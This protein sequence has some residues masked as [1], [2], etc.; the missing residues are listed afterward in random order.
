M[1]KILP[2]TTWTSLANGRAGRPLDPRRVKGIALHYPA[3]GNVK[4]AGLTQNEIAVKL[5]SYRTHHV[6]KG[7]ADIGYNFAVDQ[8]GRVWNLTGWNIGAHAGTQGNPTYVG[9][10]LVLGNTEQPSTSMI[11]ALRAFRTENLLAKYPKATDVKG[12]QQIPGNSTACPGKPVLDLI[13]SKQ[14]LDAAPKP[15]PKPVP[16]PTSRWR[17]GTLNIPLDSAKLP[18]GESRVKVAAEQIHKANLHFVACQELDRGYPDDT[19][20]YGRLLLLA[21]REFD[22]AWRIIKPTTGLNENISFY[23]STK[24]TLNGIQS[25]VILRST[26]GGRHCSRA[27]LKNGSTFVKIRNTHLVEGKANGEAREAQ[28]EQIANH[29]DKHSVILGDFNQPEIPKAL[30]KK[31]KSARIA[32]KNSSTREYGTY[33]KLT[34]TKAPVAPA[35]LLD[36][37]LVPNDAT[38]NGYTVVG[39]TADGIIEQPRASD[40]FLTIVSVTFAN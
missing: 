38:V 25:D 35:G 37:I 3:D 27:T 4:N 30:A 40:H 6:N 36:H 5:R 24:A 33:A 14:L 13:A 31:Y 39:I 2:R 32:A 10:L 9:V 18:R 15:K 29:V 8:A 23:R 17:F 7:W 19:W 12:H 28:A 11:N 34:A 22:P 26:A 1:V 21:L 20:Y 16:E